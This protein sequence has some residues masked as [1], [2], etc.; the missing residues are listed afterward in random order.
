MTKSKSILFRSVFK[1]PYDIQEGD[2]LTFQ[3]CGEAKVT[4]IKSVKFID[5]RTIEVIGLCRE[6]N[7]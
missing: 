6:V 5:M 1:I 4:K 7:L 2:I 3:D